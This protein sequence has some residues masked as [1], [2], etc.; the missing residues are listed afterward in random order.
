MSLLKI[1]Y[2]VNGTS[3]LAAEKYILQDTSN[4]TAIA[5]GEQVSLDFTADGVY[6]TLVPVKNQVKITNATIVSWNCKAPFTK[7]TLEINNVVDSNIDVEII[8]PVKVKVAPQL[9]T[10]P[11]LAKV[12]APID[13]RLV[14]SK[15]EMLE[16]EEANQ[17]DVYFALCKEDGHFYL[18]NKN[19]ISNTETGKFTLISDYINSENTEFDCGEITL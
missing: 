6:F 8:I 5:V 15:K 9:V 11:F 13:S 12:N 10:K 2:S 3:P 18:Y 4:P 19:S 7:A 17:P 1:T 16:I 14:L